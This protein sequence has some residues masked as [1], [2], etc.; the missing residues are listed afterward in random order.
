M[1]K[2]HCG[3]NSGNSLNLVKG[4]IRWYESLAFVRVLKSWIGLSQH[5]CKLSVCHRA[6]LSCANKQP[7]ASTGFYGF[8]A[9]SNPGAIFCFRPRCLIA[10]LRFLH[11]WAKSR[12]KADTCE[13]GSQPRMD[14][15]NHNAS[16]SLPTSLLHRSWMVFALVEVRC[17]DNLILLCVRRQ[18]SRE[19]GCLLVFGTDVQ[20]TTSVLFVA[21]FWLSTPSKL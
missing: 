7:Y 19:S 21:P 8:G 10:A 1:L 13:T 20:R 14:Q 5:F 15:L 12:S 11:C 18:A 4:R 2:N 9:V 6:W 17:P 3:R 16:V